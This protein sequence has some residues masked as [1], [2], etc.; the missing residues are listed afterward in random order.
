MK[1][2]IFFVAL[3]L[4]NR[5]LLHKNNW[6][7]RTTD[8]QILQEMSRRAS[9]LPRQLFSYEGILGFS[10]CL[11]GLKMFP[12]LKIQNTKGTRRNWMN[13]ILLDIQEIKTSLKFFLYFMTNRNIPD[14]S[15]KVYKCGYAQ[16]WEFIFYQWLTIIPRW[17][18]QRRYLVCWHW[19]LDS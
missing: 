10:K 2:S 13:Q 9:F 17:S 15:G 4:R 7:S 8:L 19:C 12:L 18:I 16:G 1:M 6:Y 14:P 11:V 5:F 3:A